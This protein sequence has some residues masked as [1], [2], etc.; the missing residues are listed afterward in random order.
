MMLLQK[1]AKWRE[2]DPCECWAVPVPDSHKEK[3]RRVGGLGYAF[4][5]ESLAFPG[6][7]RNLGSKKRSY[8]PF[9]QERLEKARQTTK[10][11]SK[12]RPF[13]AGT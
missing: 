2:F 1:L 3:N 8:I 6:I 10:E 7:P 5:Q 12:I 13:F 11:C 4:L 9:L